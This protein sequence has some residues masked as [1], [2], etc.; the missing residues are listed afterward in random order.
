MKAQLEETP[1]AARKAEL[2]RGEL[3]A[4]DALR[5]GED[6]L[7]LTIDADDRK[8][9]ETLLAGENRILEMVATGK[10]LADILGEMCRLVAS[11]SNDS[12]A[13]FLLVVSDNCMRIW[14]ATRDT[15]DF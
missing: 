2:L 13:T 9:D 15:I 14:A 3:E 6:Y 11:I 8:K 5:R 10:P 1:D 12:M 4:E 7:R